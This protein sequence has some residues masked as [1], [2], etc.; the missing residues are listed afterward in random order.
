M[1]IPEGA[2][3]IQ[4]TLAEELRFIHE[5]IE[6]IE[7]QN[8]LRFDAINEEFKALSVLLRQVLLTFD[9]MVEVMDRAVANDERDDD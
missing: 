2:N 9:R 6:A 4:Q 7:L 1:T 3:M 5:H 8:E